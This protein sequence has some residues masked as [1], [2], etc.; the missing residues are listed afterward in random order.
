MHCLKIHQTPGSGQG[1]ENAAL[2]IFKGLHI[3]KS[4]IFK[5]SI[6]SQ[7]VDSNKT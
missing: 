3:D 2:Y 5:F 7:V 1:Q 4:A 6:L